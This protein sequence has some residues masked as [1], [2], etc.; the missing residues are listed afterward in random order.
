[1]Y[2]VGYNVRFRG[3]ADISSETEPIG[4]VLAVFRSIMEMEDWK[5]SGIYDNLQHNQVRLKA[6]EP[7]HSAGNGYR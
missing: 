7:N 5:V 3:P 4:Y 6:N 2:R 1:M